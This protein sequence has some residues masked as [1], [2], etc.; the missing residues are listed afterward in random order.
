MFGS[1]I[2]YGSLSVVCV[3]GVV[4]VAIF[5]PETKGRSREQ[6][7]SQLA[8]THIPYLYAGRFVS[9]L[10]VGVTTAIN[11]IYV[12][13]IAEDE[14]RGTLGIY[15]ELMITVGILWSFII[16][17]YSP[18]MW[19]SISSAVIPVIFFGAFMFMPESPIHLLAA[20][21]EMKAEEALKWLRVDRV[22][23]RVLLLISL[24]SM[25]ICHALF[26]INFG[27][28]NYN[29][30]PATYSFIPL[31]AMSVYFIAFSLGM[32][33]I[34]WFMVAELSPSESKEKIGSACVLSL[35]NNIPARA[36]YIR[37][38]CKNITKRAIGVA[39]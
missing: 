26:A 11:P 19:F 7:E 30:D 32:G 29:L 33:P 36:H 31:F 2:T 34:P 23:R 17:S 39:S 18:Y 3:L 35:V 16:G 12:D 9:G 14:V 37:S 15:V 6:T 5:V 21:H 24:T 4:F 13:E 25:S 20:G 1:M 8:E 38:E 22:G 10:S 27:L 28:R